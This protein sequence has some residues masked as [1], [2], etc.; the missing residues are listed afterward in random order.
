MPGDTPSHDSQPTRWLAYELHDGL[1]QWVVGARFQLTAALQR[2][3]DHG[4]ATQGLKRALKSLDTALLEGRSLIA[5]LEQEH[6]HAKPA[7][8]DQLR[9]FVER[10]R[11]EV[12]SREQQIGARFDAVAAGVRIDESTSWNLL[13][14]AQQAVQNAIRHAGPATIDITLQ[15]QASRLVLDISDSGRGFE[16]SASALDKSRYGLRSMVHRAQLVGAKLEFNSAVGR[17]TQIH[18]VLELPSQE[19]SSSPLALD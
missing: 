8:V 11:P 6:P 7:L 9:E 2:L 16:Y 5:Y 10:V 14:I 17:G 15:V 1:L 18:C 4:E 19:S 12:E 13:R 3:N